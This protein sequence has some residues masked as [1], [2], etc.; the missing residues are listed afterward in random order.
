[1]ARAGIGIVR[2]LRDLERPFLEAE[3][4]QREAQVGLALLIIGDLIERFEVRE[5]PQRFAR[6]LHGVAGTEKIGINLRQQQVRKRVLVIQFGGLPQSRD[7]VGMASCLVV[8]D[9]GVYL[10]TRVVRLHHAG[11]QERVQRRL[12][13]T[14]LEPEQAQASECD[15]IGR[16]GLQCA[17]ECLLCGVEA[18]DEGFK[19]PELAF[20]ARAGGVELERLQ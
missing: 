16:I 2:L 10:G 1:M 11:A 17:R 4:S 19:R 15:V 13:T 8:R 20:V 7:R 5:T 3:K 9:R 12:R 18:I 14:L 6:R